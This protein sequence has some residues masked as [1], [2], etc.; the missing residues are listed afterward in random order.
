MSFERFAKA[1]RSEKIKE[2][3]QKSQSLERI[4]NFTQ[5]QTTRKR[6]ENFNTRSRPR[7]RDKCS[8]FWSFPVSF[9]RFVLLLKFSNLFRAVCSLS[10]WLLLLKFLGFGTAVCF[11]CWNC[12]VSFARFWSFCWNSAVSFERFAA[13]AKIPCLLR[14]LLLCWN[15]LSSSSGLLLALKFFSLFQVV[16]SFCWNFFSLCRAVASCVVFFEGFALLSRER[17]SL[18]FFERFVSSADASFSSGLLLLLK[19]SSLSFGR[20]AS[21]FQRF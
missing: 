1:N 12:L 8:L 18:V 13:F 21:C 3:Q 6:L 10:A 16:C 9:E 17:N 14:G 20:F 15:F 5:K 11:L 7:D 19:V 2:Y 4:K